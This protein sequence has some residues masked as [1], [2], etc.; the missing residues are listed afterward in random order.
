MRLRRDE[1]LEGVCLQ[2][3]FIAGQDQAGHAV[4]LPV[5]HDN[6]IPTPADKQ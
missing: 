5:P 3:S 2:G 1:I 4:W 6:G